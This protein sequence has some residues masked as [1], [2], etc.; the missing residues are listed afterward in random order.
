MSDTAGRAANA[1]YS[2]EGRNSGL[3]SAVDAAELMKVSGMDMAGLVQQSPEQLAAWGAIA[4]QVRPG[5]IAKL[6]MMGGLAVNGYDGSDRH[7]PWHLPESGENGL[8]ITTV[9]NGDAADLETMAGSARIL[10]WP[11]KVI[12]GEFRWGQTR[13]KATRP[14]ARNPEKSHSLCYLVR[15]PVHNWPITTLGQCA[16]SYPIY[17]NEQLIEAFLRLS[18]SGQLLADTVGHYD[19]GQ[20]VFIAVKIGE[21]R[22]VCGDDPHDLML[23]GTLDHSGEGAIQLDIG[24]VRRFCDNTIKLAKLNARSVLSIAHK[25]KADAVASKVDA[26]AVELLKAERFFSDYE[27]LNEKLDKID[28][29][30]D[31]FAAEIAP[32]LIQPEGK[33]DRAA[34]MADTK[35][36]ALVGNYAGSDTLANLDF[37]GRR[38][39][40]A[41]SEHSQWKTDVRTERGRFMSAWSEQGDTVKRTRKAQM[42]VQEIG[43]KRI[44]K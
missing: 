6:G 14:D 33:G 8:G 38:V 1:Q 27:L 26:G 9:F 34:K 24:V 12:R 25:G 3:L 22:Y 28:V 23:T 11:M 7:L 5:M 40:Q 20:K 39:I 2:L 31:Q 13:V 21:T 44:V 19:A 16:E 10:D 30:V 32:E 15:G 42:L 35:R 36:A 41:V 29:S 17:T 37:N 43:K 4:G 18:E